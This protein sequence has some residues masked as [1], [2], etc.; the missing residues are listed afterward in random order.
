MAFNENV[1]NLWQTCTLYS[2]SYDL[3]IFFTEMVSIFDF[4]YVLTKENKRPAKECTEEN[5]VSQN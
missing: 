5:I 3:W 1:N 2:P 4:Y